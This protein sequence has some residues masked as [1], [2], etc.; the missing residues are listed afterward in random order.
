VPSSLT[1]ALNDGRLHEISAPAEF[2]AEGPFEIELVNRGESVHA[3]LHFDD[4]LSQVA[5]LSETN[6]YVE[7]GDTRAVPVKVRPNVD[8]VGGRLKV[9]TGY[10]AE[11]QFVSVTVES[12]GRESTVEVDE[13]LSEP[14]DPDDDPELDVLA[15]IG[16]VSMPVLT[17][18][19]AVVVLALLVGAVVESLVLLVASGIALG[20]LGTVAALSQ[21][22]P[23]TD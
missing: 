5:S 21:Y 9:V 14:P 23:S 10:G 4:E 18:G 13:S 8:G 16:D 3:H 11:R 6:H 1:V 12:E 22:H 20:A 2:T 19:F 17:A 15:A 7:A